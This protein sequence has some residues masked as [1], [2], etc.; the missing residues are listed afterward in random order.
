MLFS[1]GSCPAQDSAGRG[2]PAKGQDSCGAFGALVLWKGV[3]FMRLGFVSSILE[4]YTFE[5]VIDFAAREG[6]TC[7]EMA[8]W[9][10]G[11]A[12]RRYAGVT[13][14]DVDAL[15]DVRIQHIQSYCREKGVAISS[16]AFYPNN[17]DG[18][19]E[20]R[21][22]NIAHLKKV[23]EASE[24]FGVN[25]VTTF[26]GREVGKN[27]DENLKL[28]AE[29]W[30]PIVAFAEAH[31]VRIAIENCPMWFTND[32]WPGG[33]NLAISPAIWR[34]MFHIIP[35][36][37]LGLNYDP[38]HFIIQQMDYLK[39]IYEFADRIYHVHYKDMHIVKE[40]LND[41]GILANPNLYTVPKIPG[42]GDID[43]GKYISALRDI[44]YD[45][46]TC[47]E[48]E[49]R[50]FENSREDVEAAL[51]LSKRHLSQFIL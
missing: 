44:G 1:S 32:E 11:K 37:N 15:D 47:V 51:I 50:S 41:Y 38:S 12:E 30:P 16:L 8:C 43:W 29:V 34:E 10:Q 13:H 21:A 20:Q 45:G 2:F 18:D 6:Y 24:R 5:E 28:Y 17:M 7:V 27:I 19:L 46:Y 14:I 40:K 39:P 3:F 9:P 22:H 23:I 31:H 42:L 33:K 35:S 36:R 4:G 49:D 48:V 25:M 26:I